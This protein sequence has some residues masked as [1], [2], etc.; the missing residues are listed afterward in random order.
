[1]T[2][3]AA[4]YLRVSSAAQADDDKFGL[5]VQA[6]AVHHYAERH[7]LTLTDTY[8]DTI[9]GTRHRRENLD[10][11]LDRAPAYDAVIISSV[12]R[13]GRRNRINYAVLDELLDTGLEVHSTDMGIVDPED[14]GSMLQFGVRSLFAESDHRRLVSKLHKARVAK[15]AG[16]PLKGR[17]GQPIWPLNGYGW[18]RG[19]QDPLESRWVRYMYDRL[20]YVGTTVLARELDELGVRTRGG[21]EWV[22][23]NIRRIISNPVYK[24]VYEFGRLSHGQG[25]V[26]A[27][28]EVP[29]LVSPELWESVNR[30]MAERTA[31][32]G[33]TTAERQALFPLAGHLR[34]GECGRR[35][36]PLTLTSR[37]GGYYACSWRTTT[38]ISRTGEPCTHSRH[39]RSADLNSLVLSTLDGLQVSDEALAAMVQ[40][41]PPAAPDHTAALADL[42]RREDRLEAAY[43]AGAYTPQE[44]AERRGDVRRQREALLATPLPL[45]VPTVDVSALRARLLSLRGLPLHEQADRLGLTVV[46]SPSGEVE[47]KLDPPVA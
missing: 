35:M 26:K 13:L 29:A 24:G 6:S 41:P 37:P 30:R 14:E 25:T 10:L 40:T 33:S 44:Y 31:R 2:R 47:L 11:L 4:V 28:C 39:Y 27:R 42:A 7:G 15:V 46:I 3:R 45:P 38:K 36:R 1:M 12:D 34:C 9:A 22:P 16:N 19:V 5:D 8:T 43:L 17:Q 20:Q 23:E 18:R 32:S 21:K